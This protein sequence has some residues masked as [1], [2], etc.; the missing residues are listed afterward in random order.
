MTAPRRGR[1]AFTLVEVALAVAVGL[2]ILGGVVVAYEAIKDNASNAKA[3]TKVLQAVSV[4][5]NYAA[6]NGGAYPPAN[7]AGGAFSTNWVAKHPQEAPE[8]PWG[9]LAGPGNGPE[10][11]V[12]EM[13]P[14]NFGAATNPVGL[15]PTGIPTSAS[16]PTTLDATYTANLAYVSSTQTASPWAAIVPSSSGAAVGVKNYA[17]G[18]HD[19]AGR[20]WFY[21]QG[22]R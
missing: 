22:G 9:G 17:M 6:A 4:L 7:P 11:G 15:D 13:A 8:S 20:P 16:I 5:E 1:L 18:I 21:V 10:D 3:R 19:K 12:V 14:V 2:V